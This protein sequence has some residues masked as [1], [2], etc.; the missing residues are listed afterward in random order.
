MARYENWLNRKDSG[1]QDP[2][3]KSYYDFSTPPPYRDQQNFLPDLEW[4]SLND[5]PSGQGPVV[6]D[7][8]SWLSSKVAVPAL[9]E[10]LGKTN[11]FSV[12][13]VCTPATG[14]G[15]NGKII[16]VSD[17]TG[18]ANLTLRQ[19][20][21]NLVFWFRNGLSARR[22]LLTWN[23]PNVFTASQTRDIVY[24]Y[25]GSNLSVYIDGKRQ[26]THYRFGPG[27]A[28]VTFLRKAK[29]GELNGYEYIYYALLF[30]PA[31]ALVGIV[32]RRFRPSTSLKFVAGVMMIVLVPLILEATLARVGGSSFSGSRLA[33]S[34]V[35]YAARAAWINA[36]RE[37]IGST[38]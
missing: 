24:T 1:A 19:E 37:P 25:D 9:A 2:S 38:I 10:D 28:L 3:L 29:L 27:T 18:V 33:L 15:A 26:P 8:S 17:L 20:D 7:G 11:Q 31:G 32:T 34:F 4:L 22:S 16:S 35:F 23:L 30:F 12:R 36:G 6:F 13:V 14:T 21:T 5:V